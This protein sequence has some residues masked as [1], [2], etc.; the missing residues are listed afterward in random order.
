MLPPMPILPPGGRACGSIRRASA[1][2]ASAMSTDT[3][4][5]ATHNIPVYESIYVYRHAL[6]CYWGKMLRSGVWGLR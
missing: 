3:V 4:R 1:S 2:T 5:V 6:D